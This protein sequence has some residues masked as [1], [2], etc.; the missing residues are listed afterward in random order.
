VKELTSRIVKDANGDSVNPMVNREAWK[1]A[2]FPT[3]GSSDMPAVVGR[4]PYRESWEIWDRI[5]LGDWPE[6]DNSDIRRG[7]KQEKVARQTFMERTGLDTLALPMVRHRDTARIVTDTDGLVLPPTDG[8]WPQQILDSEVWS[9]VKGMKGPGWL[10]IK[11]PRIARFYQ[12]KEEGIPVSHVIQAQNHGMVTGLDWGFFVFY[13]AEYDD[14]IAFPVLTDWDFCG[15]LLPTALGWLEQYVDA[16]VR[17][18]RPM[19]PPAKWPDPI[20]GEATIRTD[21][22][23]MDATDVLIYKHYEAEEAEQHRAEAESDVI[24]LLGEGEQHVAGNGVKVTRKSTTSQR[25]TDWKKFRAA[26]KLAQKNGD[27][28]ALKA[29]DPDGEEWK[30]NTATNEKVKVEVFASN[31][32]EGF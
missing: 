2:R 12:F 32:M 14:L 17:P 30:Y 23:W 18:E 13:T 27:V 3:L 29:L 28:D 16:E 4:D 20:P 25:R 26:L 9:A 7:V 21:P 19:P 10:E 8:K 15:Y 31:P 11:V 1:A 6:I 5:V 24:D 22:A